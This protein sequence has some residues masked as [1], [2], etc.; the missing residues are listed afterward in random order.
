M[1]RSRP[2][3]T[4]EMHLEG[5]YRDIFAWRTNGQ[6]P[7]Y[8]SSRTIRDVAKTFGDEAFGDESCKNYLKGL[9]YMVLKQSDIDY[10][11]RNEQRKSWAKEKGLDIIFRG[12]DLDNEEEVERFLSF[13]K[14]RPFY[15]DMLVEI[16][17][18]LDDITPKERGVG[19][20]EMRGLRIAEDARQL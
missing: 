17:D 4:K 14:L 1:N 7:C 20:A 15:E 10:S 11:I 6:K 12:V 5:V 13:I 3:T 18:V 2:A 16:L 19:E 9:N 8:A